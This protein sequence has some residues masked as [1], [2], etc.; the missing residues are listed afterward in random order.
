MD[1]AAII[2][3]IGAF[4]VVVFGVATGNLGIGGLVY[5]WNAPST[6]YNLMLRI[7]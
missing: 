7:M 5:L 3:T 6:M 2:G 1:L 4:V